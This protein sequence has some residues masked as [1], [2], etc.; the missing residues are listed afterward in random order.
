MKLLQVLL[1]LYLFVASFSK[2]TCCERCG[3]S[4][5][6]EYEDSV[7]SDINVFGPTSEVH[8]KKC[9]FGR[10]C[11]TKCSCNKK[12]F[13]DFF[14]FI[15]GKD[16]KIHYPTL[17][18]AD[19]T[20]IQNAVYDD[21]WKV[22]Q[23]R[24]YENEADSYGGSVRA[25]A[26]HFCNDFSKKVPEI[27]L[28]IC[29]VRPFSK[30]NWSG[31][32]KSLANYFSLLIEEC[33]KNSTPKSEF[34]IELDKRSSKSHL[35]KSLEDYIVM[36]RSQITPAKEKIIRLEMLKYKNKLI[37]NAID[38][39]FQGKF[40]PDCTDFQ[41]HLK[42]GFSSSRKNLSNTNRKIYDLYWNGFFNKIHSVCKN[43][44][45]KK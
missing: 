18:Q 37:D 4:N 35:F 13:F 31:I 22:I 2:A 6:L 10:V 30:E 40:H 34:T 14:S 15:Q 8:E 20:Q 44:V 25:I 26:R 5:I 1:L 23:Q 16:L 7:L 39:Y 9:I 45:C 21:M 38:A 28:P 27:S 42:R 3:I 41:T 11:Y 24:E 12:Q 29:G 33:L 19:Y 36:F 32:S 43:E 17:Q